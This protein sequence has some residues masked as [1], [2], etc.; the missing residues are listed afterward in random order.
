MSLKI[1]AIVFTAAN[2]V[3]LQTFELPPCGPKEVICETIYT[4]VSPGTELRV[5]GGL[6]ESRGKFPLIPGYS[7]VGRVIEVGSELK[8]WKTGELVTGRNPIAVPGVGF[9]WGGQAS[10]HRAEVTGYQC[11]LKLPEGARPWDYVALEVSAISWRGTSI[12]FPAAGETAVVIGQGLIG[13]F[14]ARWLMHHGARVIVVDLVESRLARA[15]KWGAAAAINATS[16]AREQVL[17]LAPGGADIVIEASASKP[18]VELA[19][20]II[21]QPI[22]RVMNTNYPLASMHNDPHFWPRLVYLAGFAGYMHKHETSPGALAGGE[23]TLVLK[24]SDRTTGDRLAAME[25]IRKGDLPLAD[26]VTKPT[27]VAEAPKAYFQL[28]DHPDQYNT[29]VYEW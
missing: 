22:P 1:Q 5:L 18:G 8:G 24:P 19:N 10:H 29:I 6:A 27:P 23:G 21:R 15:R 17:A 2:E 20:S 3:Q 28:R 11:V 26:I 12:A 13:A 4:F 14:A 25:R 16:D 9:L 7:W